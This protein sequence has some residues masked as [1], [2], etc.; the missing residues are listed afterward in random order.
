MAEYVER[1]KLLRLFRCYGYVD[2]DTVRVMEA[3]DVVPVVHG[4][5]LICE[6][7]NTVDSNGN[8]QKY[9]K[10][11]HCG[12]RWDDLHSAKTYFR[13]CPNCTAWMDRGDQWW[14]N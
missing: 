7:K 5:W 12:F 4:E 2:E 10:C 9:A 8:P 13:A 14:M 6:A 11:S 3:A 1:E